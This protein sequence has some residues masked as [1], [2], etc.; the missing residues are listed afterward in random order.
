LTRVSLYYFTQPPPPY[1]ALFF[2]GGRSKLPLCCKHT[3]T[4]IITRSPPAFPLHN[5]GTTG[6]QAEMVRATPSSFS[7]LFFSFVSPAASTYSQTMVVNSTT[8][9]QIIQW[10]CM[11][12]PSLTAI[13]YQRDDGQPVFSVMGWNQNQP[14][15]G[16]VGAMGGAGAAQWQQQH[17]AKEKD[18]GYCA[19]ITAARENKKRAKYAVSPHINL[20]QIEKGQILLA[21]ARERKGKEKR[22]KKRVAQ[23]RYRLK[24]LRGEINDLCG[25]E[26]MEEDDILSSSMQQCN[27]HLT[28]D[29]DVGS[30][31]STNL[32]LVKKNNGGAGKKGKGVCVLCI[33]PLSVLLLGQLVN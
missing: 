22:A 28:H 2:V 27:A 14:F 23:I 16:I 19:L 5:G 11:T 25:S 29:A 1:G 26:R 13:N 24:K 8:T 32:D 4:T 9:K 10:A 20:K 3:N 17:V 31:A 12:G 21:A 15:M 7:W 18:K 30:G 6:S 33:V